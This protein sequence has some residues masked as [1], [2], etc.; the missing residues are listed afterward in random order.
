MC[1]AWA[2]GS[3]EARSELAALARCLSMNGSMGNSALDLADNGSRLGVARTD[4]NNI[5]NIF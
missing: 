4:V 5:N 2:P 1:L 3:V